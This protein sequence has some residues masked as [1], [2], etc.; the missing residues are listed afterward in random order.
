MK[1][2]QFMIDEPLLARVD[3][4]PEARQIGRSAFL[5]RAITEYLRRKRSRE[6]AE[7]Y[8]RAYAEAPVTPEENLGPWDEQAWP[9]E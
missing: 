6:I 4:D 2:V 1:A 7:A 5:R 8:R 9:D 3:R